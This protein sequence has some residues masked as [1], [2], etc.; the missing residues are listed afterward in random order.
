[1][2]Y[3]LSV[4][5]FFDLRADCCQRAWDIVRSLVV[6]YIEEEDDFEQHR[7]QKQE[8]ENQDQKEGDP[9]TRDK[10][11]RKE[12]ERRGK[13]GYFEFGKNGLA[14]VQSKWA[15]GRTE[16]LHGSLVRK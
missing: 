7:H 8:G 5:I 2:S 16:P 1:M 3:V 15:V 6:G 10:E 14:H 9:E 4:V 12:P 13:G 11:E